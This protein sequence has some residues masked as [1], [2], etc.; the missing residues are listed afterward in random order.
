MDAAARLGGTGRAGASIASAAHASGENGWMSHEDALAMLVRDLAIQL[1]DMA[2]QL[3]E[4]V[5]VQ[6]TRAREMGTQLHDVERHGVDLASIV[7]R[8]EARCDAATKSVDVL[9]Q[10]CASLTREGSHVTAS[11]D[12]QLQ[13]NAAAMR[14]V[15]EAH[16][17]GV[18][19]R[20]RLDDQ[21]GNV[22][23]R[24]EALEKV[25]HES[26]RTRGVISSETSA[27]AARLCVI[28]RNIGDWKA[29]Y[30]Q[31]ATD[32]KAR[33]IR[34]TL[35][36]AR[37]GTLEVDLAA[38]DGA[39]ARRVVDLEKSMLQGSRD[40]LHLILK[41]DMQEFRESVL[42][43]SRRLSCVEAFVDDLRSQGVHGFS[44]EIMSQKAHHDSLTDQFK[45][46]SSTMAKRLSAMELQAKGIDANKVNFAELFIPTEKKLEARF[47]ASL[48]TRNQEIQGLLVESQQQIERR[49][50]ASIEE[51]VRGSGAA[52]IFA[53]WLGVIT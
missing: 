53:A 11:L 21:L 23:C 33:E 9:R 4:Q 47:R 38:K 5:R 6:A 26:G 42:S 43:T 32:S 40:D 15:R 3:D 37:V 1:Q 50:K 46:H 7:N 2:G 13:E 29:R 36:N 44:N 48:E 35:F 51:E 27:I 10:E 49:F 24:L 17:A 41:Q 14:E 30:D 52:A 25:V 19:Y 16:Q 28:E 20:A 39:L 22:A 8:M 34:E 45:D 12:K 31:F 18:A